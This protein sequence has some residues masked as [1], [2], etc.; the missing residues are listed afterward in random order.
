MSLKKI[1]YHLILIIKFIIVVNTH[2]QNTTILFEGEVLHEKYY[3]KDINIINTSSNIGTSSDENGKFTIP[4]KMGDSI[5]FS[6][7]DYKNKIIKISEVHLKNNSIIV[8]LETQVNELNEVVLNN[9]FLDNIGYVPVDERA[10]LPNDHISDK[11]APNALKFTD[12][13]AKMYGVS[14]RGIIWALTKKLRKKRKTQKETQN[15]VN[16]LKQQFSDKIRYAYGDAFF[17]EILNISPSQINL[18]LD[19]C[20]NKG[21]N[22]FY[23]SEEFIIKDFLIKQSITFKALKH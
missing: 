2:G 17:T 15:R 12:P 8:N 6:S 23:D 13:N 11:S 4:A 16:I 18:F 9:G 22:N 21:L 20:Q 7:I 3:L 19:Y 14:L 5:L 1:K 10:A